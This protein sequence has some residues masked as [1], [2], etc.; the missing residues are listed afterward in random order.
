MV[1]SPTG[2]H[3][4]SDLFCRMVRDLYPLTGTEPPRQLGPGSFLVVGNNIGAEYRW[5]GRVFRL[6]LWDRAL[7]EQLGRDLTGGGKVEGAQD[8]LIGNCEFSGP[9]PLQDRQKLFP[10]FVWTPSVPASTDSNA[11]VLDGKSWVTSKRPVSEFV[12]DVQRTSQ[13]A[14]RVV[15]ILGKVGEGDKR[16]VS[17]SDSSGIMNLILRQASEQ[18]IGFSRTFRSRL[19]GAQL[20]TP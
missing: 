20:V 13:F 3:D 8:G 9:S 11:L 18:Q 10:D 17:I 15:G 5:L 16:I 7:P 19:R 14:V 6:Q 4:Y 1:N 12:R 2:C